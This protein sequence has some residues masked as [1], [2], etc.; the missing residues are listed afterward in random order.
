MNLQYISDNRGDI[1]GVFIPIRD[2][3]YLKNKFK[4]IEQ[5]EI[6]TSENSERRARGAKQRS[7]EYQ[8]NPDNIVDWDNIQKEIETE[9]GF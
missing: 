1:T 5:E 7:H 2:W 8:Y 4:E 9:Y 6:G 3:N